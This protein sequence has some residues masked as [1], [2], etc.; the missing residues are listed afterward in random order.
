MDFKHAMFRCLSGI[1]I[2]R[3][4]IHFLKIKSNQLTL[5]CILYLQS[6]TG[7]TSLSQP[8]VPPGSSSEVNFEALGISNPP[9]CS[10]MV[11]DDAGGTQLVQVPK[12]PVVEGL[13]LPSDLQVLDLSGCNSFFSNIL[14]NILIKNS[15][16]ISRDLNLWFSCRSRTKLLISISWS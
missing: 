4:N 5:Y 9:S 2:S 14:S 6:A 8:S 1:L 12:A 15:F 13:P 3:W 7:A 16:F 11:A 10:V